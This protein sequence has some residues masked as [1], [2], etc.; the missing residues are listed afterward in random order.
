MVGYKLNIYGW[1]FQVL[2]N[3]VY[4]KNEVMDL[5]N[6][7]VCI[8]SGKYFNQEG[9]VINFIGGYIVE[10]FF[11]IEEE[12]VNSVMIFGIDIV[13]GDIK[14]CDINNDGKIDGEDCVYIGNIMFKWIFGLNLFVEWKGFDVIFLFQG[15]VDV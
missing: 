5:K 12:V 9:Y 14:Y 13:L 6:G 8:W 11:K 2:V 3:V 15:V 4:N 7:G 10:G 1:N